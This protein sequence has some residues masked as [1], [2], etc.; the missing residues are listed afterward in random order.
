M[1]KPSSNLDYEDQYIP[2]VEGKQKYLEARPSSISNLH[3]SGFDGSWSMEDGRSQNQ[4]ER[5]C[6]RRNSLNWKDKEHMQQVIS[7]NLKSQ[8]PLRFQDTSDNH[9]YPICPRGTA[10]I[11]LKT[12]SEF[13]YLSVAFSNCEF[14]FYS[15]KH[16]GD[17]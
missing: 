12:Y 13:F 4:S 5:C 1:R 14:E 8:T 15:E 3:R 16:L 17:M 11:F 10:A 9:T 2:G 7:S 6:P